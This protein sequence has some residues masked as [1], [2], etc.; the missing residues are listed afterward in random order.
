MIVVAVI[1]ILLFLHA[2]FDSWMLA[3]VAVL[4]LPVA[5]AGGAVAAL[6]GGGSLSF[7]SLFG[8]M[9]LLAIAVRNGLVMTK[10]FQHLARHEGETFGPELVLRGARERLAPIVMAALATAGALLPLILAGDIA[11]NE[12]ITD[13]IS[14]VILTL[15]RVVKI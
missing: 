1:G 6:L 3:A 7:G 8:F 12:K 13:A 9:T 5:L 2:S 14:V 15:N 11:G 10:H 4:T